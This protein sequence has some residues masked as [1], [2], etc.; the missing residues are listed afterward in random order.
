MAMQGEVSGSLARFSSGQFVETPERMVDYSALM[1]CRFLSHSLSLS[2]SISLALSFSSPAFSLCLY[3]S[4]SSLFLPLSCPLYASHQTIQKERAE[5]KKQQCTVT[6]QF[7]AKKT[8][9]A[10]THQIALLHLPR[11]TNMRFYT[12]LATPKR[13]VP[14][15]TKLHL[16]SLDT[17][18]G[19]L[20]REKKTFT[21][22][23]ENIS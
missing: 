2:P 16:E 22:A 12:C 5:R 20:T 11:H 19:D 4:V 6:R 15:H 14:G 23:H 1:C 17:P 8:T 10:S 13:H 7:R 3:K 21:L 18:K 9:F